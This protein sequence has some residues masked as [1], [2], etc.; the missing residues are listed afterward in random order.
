MYMI[1]DIRKA[2]GCAKTMIHDPV[3]I[4][5]SAKGLFMRLKGS[6]MAIGLVNSQFDI[7]HVSSACI[8]WILLRMP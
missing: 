3:S 5:F 6:S 7:I 4:R 1:N 8:K 2:P